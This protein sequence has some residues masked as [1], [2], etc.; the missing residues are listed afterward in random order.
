MRTILRRSIALVASVMVVGVTYAGA[1]QPT[2]KVFVT[3][4][5]TK[6]HRASCSSLSKSKIE[7]TLSE[8]AARYTP[9]KICRPP[10]LAT[11]DAVSV[12]RSAGSPPD[13]ASS[14][15]GS[16]CQATTRK[17]TQCSQRA[18]PG[19]KFCWQHGG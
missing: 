15:E 1:Q 10:V 12:S 4:T 18:K 14:V 16:R 17:G 8:A 13:K 19:S 7:L 6:Y 2:D 3:K 9:C 5:G 11:A